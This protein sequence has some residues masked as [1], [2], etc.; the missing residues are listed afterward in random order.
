M[1]LKIIIFKKLADLHD[2]CAQQ[3]IKTVQSNPQAKI[4][5]ATGV[6][7]VAAYQ[8]VISD[9]QENKTDWSKVVT[10]NLDEFV[11]IDPHHP[12]AFIKQMK[13]NL[14]DHL[15]INPINI[16]IPDCKASDP[17]KEAQEYEKLIQKLGPIDFQYISLGIN[18]H[19]AY[20]EPGTSLTSLTHVASL[21]PETIADMVAKKKFASATESPKQ[22]ITMGVKTLL[23][24]TKKMMMVS[25][26]KHK[27][28]V[29]KIMLEDKPNTEVTASALQ[30]HPNC[31][32]V[33]DQGAASLLSPE[34]LKH[35]KWR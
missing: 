4:G 14:F 31:F 10:F 22:A 17:L 23:E 35:A 24:N 19:I 5:F 30:N 20:N 8:K 16:H 7:P 32:F 34:T 29:T 3:F 2:F 21:T 18:G 9:Y 15:N 1:N 33:L 27:A 26:G 13:D 25:Y 28:Q 11:G 12:Q 6:S